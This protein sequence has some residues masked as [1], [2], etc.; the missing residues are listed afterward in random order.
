MCDGVNDEVE[1]MV[2]LRKE[3]VDRNII[4]FKK[5]LTNS[6]V[7]LRKESVDRNCISCLR[8]VHQGV[9]LRKESVDRNVLV[10]P[11]P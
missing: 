4:F 9:A 3:S 5:L 2:A 10:L 6:R 11:L 8:C 7:A 1:I